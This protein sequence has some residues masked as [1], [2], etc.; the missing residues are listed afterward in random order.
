MNANDRDDAPD[1]MDDAI[2]I[3][4][5]LDDFSERL[6]SDK[7]GTLGSISVHINSNEQTDSSRAVNWIDFDAGW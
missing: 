1:F 4:R 7:Q 2:R 6:T 3:E 5:I